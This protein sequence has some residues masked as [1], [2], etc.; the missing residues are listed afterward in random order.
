[1]FAAQYKLNHLIA[2][3]D[4]NQQQADGFTRD[5]SDLGDLTQKFAD[6]GWSAQSVDGHDVARIYE[7]IVKAKQQNEKPAMIVLNTV[8]GKGCGFAEGKLNNHNMPVTPEM[9]VEAVK[10]LETVL[11]NYV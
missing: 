2:F 4:Y 5:I 6:F 1:L 8:K 11:A 3:I 9:M 7:A 10:E